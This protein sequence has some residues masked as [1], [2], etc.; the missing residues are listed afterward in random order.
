M[1][2]S[3]VRSIIKKGLIEAGFRNMKLSKGYKEWTGFAEKDNKVIYFSTP[4][5]NDFEFKENP[6][7]LI[8]TVKDSKDFTG[9][10]N[11][12]CEFTVEAIA[13]L[14]KKLVK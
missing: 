5:I 7:C 13:E 6:K 11:N 8:R 3:K 4:N 1:T 10:T 9:G 14:A 2:L 12:F